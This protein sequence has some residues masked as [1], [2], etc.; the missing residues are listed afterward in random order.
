MSSKGPPVFILSFPGGRFI[1]L[2]PR[3]LR[4]WV[5]DVSAPACT[6]EMC[7]RLVSVAQRNR[8]F[9][10]LSFTVQSLD[11]PMECMAWRF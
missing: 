11:L 8:P 2:S 3:Q 4:H 5:S 1:P 9:T 6:N 7:L 10:K